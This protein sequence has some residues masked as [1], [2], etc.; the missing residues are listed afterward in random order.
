MEKIVILGRGESLKRL[1]ELEINI[2]TIILCN[3]F[4]TKD[5]GQHVHTK[6]YWEDELIHNFIKDKKIYMICSPFQNFPQ[7]DLNNFLQKYN[8]IKSYFT[9]FS[10]YARIGK[11]NAIFNLLP[12][13]VL[14]KY[15][16]YDK[17]KIKKRGA[18]IPGSIAMAILFATEELKC[19]EIYIF[20]QD[21]YEKDY[22]IPNNLKIV[23]PKCW[24]NHYKISE[25]QQAK[26]DLTNFLKHLS[27]N[28][29]YIYTLADYNPNINN[30]I[31]K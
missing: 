12:D 25:V 8:V 11:P 28:K 31:I 5:I 19:K 6:A 26:I 18:P 16:E 24:E 20:G 7:P 29:F 21:F 3:S 15:I 2:D 9:N 14:N 27:D 17:L 4:F 23:N 30:I 10:R 1:P 22:Y 13:S